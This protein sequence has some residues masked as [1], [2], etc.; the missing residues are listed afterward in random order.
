[1]KASFVIVNY[2]RKDEL[3][4]T[5]EKSKAVINNHAIEYEFVIVD[6][7]STDGSA[8]AVAR[9][10][11]DVVLIA[12][13]VNAGAPAW[14][15]GFAK[16]SGDYFII[17]DDDSH[18]E[19]GLEEALH[20]IDSNRHI[21]ILALN[22]VSGPYTSQDWDMKE[23]NSMIGFIGC[24]AIFSRA[25]YEKIGGYAEWIFLYVNEWELGLRCI[26]AGF[27]VR[28]F[29]N[30]RVIHRTSPSHRSTRRLDTLVIKHELAIIYKYLPKQ[31]W[32][33]IIRAA[34]YKFKLFIKSGEYK[35]LW[36]TLIGIKQFMKM[37]DQL[38][39]TPVSP[40]VQSLYV[41]AFPGT[42]RPVFSFITKYF[43]A[44]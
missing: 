36:Y 44:V 16:A 18:I 40:Q 17:L 14:N 37:K 12:K 11:P 15:D 34:V 39:Y 28:F 43:Q 20:Y 23:G 9:L 27:Q 1:M 10:H 33:Y 5:I 6:N 7:G 32:N 25:A 2:N 24:G 3:L 22:I 26:E 29:E 31:R 21:G 8:E 35:R 42:Q 19:S 41:K 4:T 13:Q 38:A 30:C